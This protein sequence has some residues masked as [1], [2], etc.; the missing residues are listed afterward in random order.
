[1]VERTQVVV[2]EGRQ[3]LLVVVDQEHVV[4]RSLLSS[5]GYSMTTNGTSRNRHPRLDERSVRLLRE[6]RAGRPA[7]CFNSSMAVFPFLVA[8]PA[9]LLALRLSVLAAGRL[10]SS[11]G[12][13]RPSTGPGGEHAH[14]PRAVS[15]R[16]D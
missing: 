8:G 3:R 13:P 1:G 10:R 16:M 11:Q 15:G 12:A 4:H 2:R 9:I 7:R 6:G 14:P 5:A